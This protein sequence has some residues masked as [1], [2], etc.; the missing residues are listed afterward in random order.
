MA[1]KG[2]KRAAGTD[3]QDFKF[4]QRVDNHYKLMAGARKSLKR[5]GRV[6]LA[7]A[8]GLASLTGTALALPVGLDAATLGICA[9]TA[10][11]SGVAGKNALAA[12][13]A[14]Q[15]EQRL[16]SYLTLCKIQLAL[17]FS[18]AGLTATML[19]T[20][21]S[22]EISP[23]VVACVLAVVGIIGAMLGTSSAGAL[24]TAFEEQAKK[25]AYT[26]R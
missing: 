14:Q 1:S 5:A 2:G 7:S 6:Q 13:G 12:A 24:I 15:P 26:S 18:T 22:S 4:R 19:L 3:G 8:L 25:K 20:S 16:G 10:V 11:T 23:L 17:L 9:A 21:P